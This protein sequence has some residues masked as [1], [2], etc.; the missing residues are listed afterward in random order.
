MPVMILETQCRVVV[1]RKEEEDIWVRQET[2]I[3]DSIVQED[4]GEEED[5][6]DDEDSV[7]GKEICQVTDVTE[8][9]GND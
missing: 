2:V 8:E 5:K 6:E 1:V 3:V 7:D 4:P 9:D